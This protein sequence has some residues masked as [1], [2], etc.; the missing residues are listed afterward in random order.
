[1]YRLLAVKLQLPDDAVR[2]SLDVRPETVDG[3]QQAEDT[4]LNNYLVVL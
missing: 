3:G 4:V 2:D 1:M